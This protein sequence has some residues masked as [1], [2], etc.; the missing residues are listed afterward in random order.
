MLTCSECE[1]ICKGKGNLNEHKKIHLSGQIC[2][3]QK[4]V[5]VNPTAC[6]QINNQVPES[7][8]LSTHIMDI[9]CHK[10]TKTISH[11]RSLPQSSLRSEEKTYQC[12]IC[13]KTFPRESDLKGHMTVHGGEKSYLSSICDK[14]FSRDNVLKGH[15]T[16]HSEE[17]TYQLG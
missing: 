6:T 5:V 11:K 8:K 4:Q 2:S 3:L 14:T 17:K 13:D 9:N 15:K 7:I 10:E 1:F 16:I 12:S